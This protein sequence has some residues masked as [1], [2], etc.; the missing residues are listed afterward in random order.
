MAVI[1]PGTGLGVAACVPCGS[2]WRALATKGGH[3]T[4]SAA[5]DLENEVL[6]I[7]RGRHAHASA[8]RLLS[9]IG[10]WLLHEAVAQASGAAIETLA[11]HEITRRALGVGDPLCAQMLD[12]F[13]AMLGA[14]AGNA[15]LTLGARG[16]IFV[17]GGI[18]PE[19][20]AFFLPSRFRDRFE[21]KGRLRGYLARVPT[22]LITA[23]DAALIGA[24]C[25]IEG[26][27]D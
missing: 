26:A 9:G 8:E 14:F 7:V 18:V 21:D 20:G 27:L 1:G 16:G 24:A 11:A 22:A 23:T 17:A 13:R 6:R 25:A 4:A 12:T 10:L 19:L 2:S 15:A 5:D 3:A